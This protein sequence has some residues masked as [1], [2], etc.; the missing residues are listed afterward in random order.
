MRSRPRLHPVL[1]R[2]GE[3]VGVRDQLEVGA[4]GKISVPVAGETCVAANAQEQRGDAGG[5]GPRRHSFRARGCKAQRAGGGASGYAF[6]ASGA[7]GGTDGDQTV[8]RQRGWARF[9]ALRAIDA[10]DWDRAGCATGWPAL[11]SP[12]ARRTDKDSGT[13]SSG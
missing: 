13:R 5:H 6:Q 8:H 10:Q 7:F 3:F 9:G 1:S 11:R 4:A 2:M 12:S